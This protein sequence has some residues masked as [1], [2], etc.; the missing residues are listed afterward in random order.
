MLDRACAQATKFKSWYSL[1]FAHLTKADLYLRWSRYD[2]AEAEVALARSTL[3]QSGGYASI[4]WT[5]GIVS[6]RASSVA[7]LQRNQELAIDEA[8]S[9]IAIGQLYNM[10]PGARARFSHLLMKAYL[11]SPERY[12]KKRKR[13]GE[14]TSD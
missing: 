7:I 6:Y 3:N 13:L 10:A 5:S 8:K 12:G 4:S 14:R 2:S 11:M 9:A 1:S